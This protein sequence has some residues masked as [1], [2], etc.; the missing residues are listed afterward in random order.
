[1]KRFPFI[2]LNAWRYLTLLSLFLCVVSLAEPWSTKGSDEDQLFKQFTEKLERQHLSGRKVDRTM[3]EGG[4]CEFVN[5]LDRDRLYFTNADI[6]ALNQF[7]AGVG[8][9]TGH[10]VATPNAGGVAG[11]AIIATNNSAVAEHTYQKFLEASAKRLKMIEDILNST[12]DLDKTEQLPREGHWPDYARTEEDLRSRWRLKL[13]HDLIRLVVEKIP[14]E[15]AT[16]NLLERYRRDERAARELPRAEFLAKVL[17]SVACCMDPF[18][19]FQLP[20][21][22]DESATRRTNEYIGMGV[23]FD[24]RDGKWVVEEIQPGSPAERAGGLAPG[25]ELMAVE[26]DAGERRLVTALRPD[27]V[28]AHTKREKGIPVTL[29][30]K[31]ADGGEWRRVKIV[32]DAIVLKDREVAYE[33]VVTPSASGDKRVR[34]IRLPSFYAEDDVFKLDR[35]RR[36]TATAVRRLVDPE[37]LAAGVPPPDAVVLDMRGNSGGLLEQAILTANIFVG[38]GNNAVLIRERDRKKASGAPLFEEAAYSGPL[39]V[40]VDKRSASAAE[41]LTAAIQGNGRGIVIGDDTFGKGTI[42]SPH[43]LEIGLGKAKRNAGAVTVTEAMFYSVDGTPIQ[44]DGLPADI[45]FETALSTIPNLGGAHLRNAL[46]GDRLDVIPTPKHGPIPKEIVQALS[47]LHQTR[48]ATDPALQEVSRLLSAYAKLQRPSGKISLQLERERRA[49]E[50]ELRTALRAAGVLDPAKTGFGSDPYS[51]EVQRI[52]A[53][54][55]DAVD[56]VDAVRKR[57]PSTAP[58]A[59]KVIALPPETAPIR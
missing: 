6:V 17:N 29:L 35:D 21:V 7:K 26:N 53:D 31:P 42:H 38:P 18:T 37:F 44:G 48:M 13:K 39:A 47:R 8:V 4:N 27:E 10:A 56:A 59:P 19:S 3:S 1:M 54:Y 30:V 46:P 32:Q 36:S 33:D 16:K 34:V 40:L 5:M 11:A 52:V 14:R 45:A 55:V 24:T 28:F 2:L 12:I 43:S 49:Q 41:V 51:Q 22:C 20:Q 58:R 50:A 25:D 9:N 15:E 23:L 57:Q